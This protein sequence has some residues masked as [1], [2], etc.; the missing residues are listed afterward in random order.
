MGGLFDLKKQFNGGE[1]QLMEHLF[2]Q[3][4]CNRKSDLRQLVY[5]QS[6]GKALLWETTLAKQR[7]QSL[8]VR[9]LC[10]AMR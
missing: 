4:V 5:D 7:V 8:N 3:I 9:F 2:K 1:P 10:G 6:K